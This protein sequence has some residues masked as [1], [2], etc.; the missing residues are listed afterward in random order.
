MRKRGMEKPASREPTSSNNAGGRV[1][2]GTVG[3]SGQ[4]E[5]K[6]AS[7]GAGEAFDGAE[8]VGDKVT[9]DMKMDLVAKV[10]KLS[11][12]GLT[13]LVKHVQTVAQPAMSE[14]EDERV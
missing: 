1:S 2:S 9:V 11:N 4:E 14:L 6:Q 7:F 3:R 5:S 8:K 12:E 10:K 13:K